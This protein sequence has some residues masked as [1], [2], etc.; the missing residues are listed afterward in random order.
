MLLVEVLIGI[1]DGM[2]V[3]ALVVLL[4]GVLLVKVLVAAVVLLGQQRQ[5]SSSR[6]LVH[7]YISN[8]RCSH[9]TEWVL[10]FF[11]LHPDKPIGPYYE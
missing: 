10:C 9:C 4:V 2:L 7:L 11:G 3:G 6:M 8:N 1:L 5:R